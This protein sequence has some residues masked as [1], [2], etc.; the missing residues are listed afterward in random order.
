MHAAVLFE[1]WGEARAERFF[2]DFTAHGGKLVAS[3]G[4]VRRRV[5][6]GEFAFGLTDSDD[7]SVALRDRQPVGFIVPDQSGD[8]V[9]LIP[10]AAVLIKGAPHPREA[11][12]L[13]DFLVSADAERWMAAGEAAHLPLRSDLTPPPFLGKRAAD[14]RVMAVDYSKLGE[15]MQSL[16]DGFLTKWVDEQRR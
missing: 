1:R 13:I 2:R 8:G 3:N 11:R 16:M 12:I 6:A 7:V 10:S 4:E 15:R 5:A 14:L 9:L